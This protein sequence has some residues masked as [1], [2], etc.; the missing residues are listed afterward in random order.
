MIV[1]GTQ[2]ALIVFIVF[3]FL[4]GREAS[5]HTSYVDKRERLMFAGTLFWFGTI[6]L[7]ISVLERILG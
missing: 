4:A 7:L 5:N 3:G 6:I 2:I 1:T